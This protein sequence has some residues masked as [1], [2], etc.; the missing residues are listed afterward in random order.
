LAII[1]G[2]G[3]WLY[4]RHLLDLW[5][6]DF[7][8]KLPVDPWRPVT[9]HSDEADKRE[10]TILRPFKIIPSTLLPVWGGSLSY[11]MNFFNRWCPPL[12]RVWAQEYSWRTAW[13]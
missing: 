12:W 2:E 7:K 3:L 8:L 11:L 9:P 13:D 10:D 6:L 5:T 4:T 1:D